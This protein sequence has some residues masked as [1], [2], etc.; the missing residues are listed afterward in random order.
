M[1]AFLKSTLA[2]AFSSADPYA[3]GVPNDYDAMWVDLLMFHSCGWFE[4]GDEDLATAQLC[5]ID[6]VLAQIDI[7]PGQQMLDVDCGWGALVIR[8]AQQFGARCVGITHSKP[9]FDWAV[10]GVKAAGLADRVEIRL[11]AYPDAGCRF[12]RIASLGM[13]EY[14]DRSDLPGY[15][16][17]LREYLAPDG[18]LV[19]HCVMATRPGRGLSR[20]DNSAFSRRYLFTGDEPHDLGYALTAIREGGLEVSCVHNLRTHCVR[21]LRLW[22]ANFKAKEAALR[23][24]VD[25][26][27][28]RTWCNYLGDWARA[29]ELDDLSIYEIIGRNAPMRDELYCSPR[30]AG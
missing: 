3:R 11:Q 6:R 18:M 14:D 21:T 27:R 12:D 30:H 28:F 4:Q 13:L 25:E 20:F 24:L 15:V 16:D 22:E 19:C 17:A 8:A 26:R 7:K 23:H 9:Q 10:A 5:Q 29:F 1:G 2:H